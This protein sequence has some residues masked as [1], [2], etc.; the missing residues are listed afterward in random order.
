MHQ[1]IKPLHISQ[2][3]DDSLRIENYP[4]AAHVGVA[5][6]ELAEELRDLYLARSDLQATHQWLVIMASLPTTTK[7]FDDIHEALWIAS[8]TTYF[9]C[10]AQ[11]VRKTKLKK[12]DI[13]VDRPEAIELFDYFLDLRNRHLA[14]DVNA[15]I[16]CAV[17]VV[18]NP[19]GNPQKIAD[20]IAIPF[21]V[22]TARPD[23]LSKFLLLVATTQDWV[24]KR[25]SELFKLVCD[26][27]TKLPHAEL[28]ALPALKTT[29]PSPADVGKRR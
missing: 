17:G 1:P 21:R 24:D 18:V 3:A 2:N 10:F 23:F 22:V 7:S 12:E 26:E 15:F 14:H 11:G 6:G 9:K 4:T 5:S 28:L 8:I 27:Y 19:D 25:V 16:Q 20:A 29:I 13:Y